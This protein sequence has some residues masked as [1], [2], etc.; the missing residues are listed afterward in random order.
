MARVAKDVKEDKEVSSG[1]ATE[2]SKDNRAAIEILK[3]KYE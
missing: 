2:I 3:K 1:V